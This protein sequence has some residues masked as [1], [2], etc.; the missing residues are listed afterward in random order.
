MAEIIARYEAGEPSTALA[1]TFGISRNSVI[2]LLR[3]ADIPI[4]KQGLT[5]GQ[6]VKAAQMYADGMSLA[7]IGAHLGL[8]H[9]TVWR[10]LVKR[11]V[12]MRDNHG[13]ER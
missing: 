12:K 3:E 5:D 9:G 13:R 4:R 10:Q 6:I 7:K 1:S 8:D 11:G 2:K